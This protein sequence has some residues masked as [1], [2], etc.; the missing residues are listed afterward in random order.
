MGGCTAGQADPIS[1]DDVAGVVRDTLEL[2]LSDHPDLAGRNVELG[3]YDWSV[4]GQLVGLVVDGE[5]FAVSVQRIEVE[6]DA[7]PQTGAILVLPG[8]VDER[9]RLALDAFVRVNGRATIPDI[10]QHLQGSHRLGVTVA[11][12]T[13][14]LHRHGWCVE[15]RRP[16]ATRVWGPRE[17][18]VV[19]LAAE[20]VRS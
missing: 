5:R 15:G 19:D 20:K 11:W 17:P 7:P 16:D 6:P 2:F 10:R 1:N 4:D 12:V 14:Q 9:A 3:D 8:S 18:D 13:H